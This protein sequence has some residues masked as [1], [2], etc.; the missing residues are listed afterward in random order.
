MCQSLGQA[1]FGLAG[2]GAAPRAS[3]HLTPRE[4]KFMKY[5]TLSFD[6]GT[7]QDIRFVEMINKY[8]LKCTFNIN[9]GLFSNKNRIVHEGIE[10]D[11]TRI[12]AGMVSELYAGHE[13]AVHTKTHPRLDMCDREKIIDE[14]LGDKISLEALCGYDIVG[15]AYPGG[16]FYNDFVIETILE[17]TT[18]IYAR[19]I[20]S[21]RSFVFPDDLMRWRPT[22]HQNDPAIFDMARDFIAASPEEDLLFYLWGHSFE[23]DK[24]KSWDSFE[25]F[26]DLI[27]G[28]PDI[29]YVTNKT[30]AEARGCGDAA[31]F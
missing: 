13:V 8:G 5:F 24:Y 3:S 12:E 11:H 16:P 23:F 14:V 31:T 10:V 1:F 27:A 17:N 6:D 21:H 9:S 28:K 30:I 26:C 18:L 22:C 2:Y 29:T 19:N 20:D 4:R 7:V 15:M 25:R